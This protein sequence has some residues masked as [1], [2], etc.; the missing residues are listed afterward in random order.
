[1][2]PE[3]SP[4]C[5]QLALRARE[6]YEGQFETAPQAL[7]RAPGRLE[8]LG[9]HTDYNNGYILSVALE[10]SV[11]IAAGLWSAPFQRDLGFPV[12]VGALKGERLLL[13]YDTR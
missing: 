2:P 5:E 8:I 13:Q 11:V 3:I 1:M 12:P 9:N 10:L 7:S 4:S 6:S